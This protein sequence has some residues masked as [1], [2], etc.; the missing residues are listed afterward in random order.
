[1]R[2]D[3]GKNW[4][5]YLNSINEDSVS[6]AKDN[7]KLWIG[8]EDISDKRI[9]D[10][11][12]GS[13]IHSY[14]FIKLGA[15]EVVSFDFD[16][17]SVKATSL[18]FEKAGNP[19]NWHIF[20]GSILDEEFINSLGKFDIIYSWGVLHH[21]GDMWNALINSIRYFSKSNSCFWLALYQGVETYEND[22]KIKFK[23]N[24]SNFFG[25]KIIVFKDIL[26]IIK[27]RRSKGLNPF[28][29]NEKRGRGMDTYHDLID[30]LGGYPYE[31]CTLSDLENFLKQNGGWRL[32]KFN[33]EQACFVALFNKSEEDILPIFQKDFY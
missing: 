13:G 12:C 5:S 6:R 26:N 24:S 33:D 23:Y 3:F 15:K 8:D 7:I 32:K 1:M 10:I 2:F 18:L 4:L 21:T 30:W 19:I 17:N 25:K 9:I 31:V 29:W 14:S 22:L 27:K 20:Q 11:G 28:T 16:I